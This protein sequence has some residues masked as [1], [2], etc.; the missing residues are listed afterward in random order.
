MCK[1]RLINDKN[2]FIFV[3]VVFDLRRFGHHARLLLPPL[4]PHVPLHVLVHLL[5][6]QNRLEQSLLPLRPHW[7]S[8]HTHGWQQI[9]VQ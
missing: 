1:N 7:I 4:L 5:P 6:G 8:A 2:L 9:L 3:V